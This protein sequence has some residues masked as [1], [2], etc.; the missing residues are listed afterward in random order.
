MFVDFATS[1]L[2]LAWV[3]GG[4]G[5]PSSSRLAEHLCSS[6]LAQWAWPFEGAGVAGLRAVKEGLIGH[7]HSGTR[8]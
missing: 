6:G 2:W 7:M 3:P 4:T 5:P 1:A 8:I